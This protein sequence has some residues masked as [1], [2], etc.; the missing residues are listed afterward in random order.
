MVSPQAAYM[1]TRIL[2]D[3]VSQGTAKNSIGKWHMEQTS[4][5][6]K[7]PEI[8]A[9]TG[10]TND[11][12]VAWL[13]GYTPELALA[14]CI[15]YDQPRSMGPKMTGGTTVGPL[16]TK[17]M[18][19]LLATREDWQLKFE[20]P[21]NIA[22]ADICGASGKLVSGGCYSSGHLVFKH[23]AFK[24]GTEPTTNCYHGGG[25]TANSYYAQNENVN[26]EAE[27]QMDMRSQPTNQTQQP[28]VYPNS[29]YGF[30]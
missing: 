6:R 11:C 12:F 4:K 23:A 25:G 1:T 5:G 30:Q 16:Y 2:Q 20:V 29:Y 10:T 17:L 14:V 27:Y 26:P 8:A 15:G 7:L 28:V 22:F 19:R 13:V 21:E 3:V 24:A 9:K 18:D